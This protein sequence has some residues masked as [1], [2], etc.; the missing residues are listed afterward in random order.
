MKANEYIGH[1]SGESAHADHEGTEENLSNH[2]DT[3]VAHT[4]KYGAGD[5]VIATN[6]ILKGRS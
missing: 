2:H 1:D 6:D 4:A 5:I 3:T